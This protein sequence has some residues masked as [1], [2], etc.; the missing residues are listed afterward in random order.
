[1]CELGWDEGGAA[2]QWRRQLRVWEE[3]M[4]G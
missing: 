1:M 2:W 4:L 3:N